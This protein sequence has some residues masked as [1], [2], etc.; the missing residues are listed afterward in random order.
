MFTKLT[1]NIRVAIDGL[2]SNKLRSSLTMLGMTIGVAAV[3]LL[4]SVG[5]AVEAFIVNEL[6]SYG[7]N[8]VQVTGTV[9]NTA[10]MSA[11][12]VN[13]ARNGVGRNGTPNGASG[14]NS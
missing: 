9:S 1:D 8:W 2:R 10:D 7:S 6:T 12:S 4:V 13:D 3:I 11:V 14:S 5:Q